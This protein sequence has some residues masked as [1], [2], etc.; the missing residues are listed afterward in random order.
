METLKNP[1][2]IILAVALVLVAAGMYFKID[3]P[4]FIDSLST[5]AGKL[6]TLTTDVTAK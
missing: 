1:K 2:V 6:G 5:V 4:A 3:V